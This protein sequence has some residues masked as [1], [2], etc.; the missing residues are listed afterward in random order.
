[1]Q[2]SSCLIQGLTGLGR[3]VSGRGPQG[4][5]KNLLNADCQASP[6]GLLI[7]L[8]RV[9]CIFDNHSGSLWQVV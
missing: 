5:L 6:T 7:Q 2:P 8:V 9:G 4:N 3:A 1:M